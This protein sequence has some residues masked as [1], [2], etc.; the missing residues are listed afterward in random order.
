[1]QLRYLSSGLQCIYAKDNLLLKKVYELVYMSW[2]Q[3]QGP[4]LFKIQS[5]FLE[6]DHSIS[7]FHL[8]EHRGPGRKLIKT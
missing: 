5:R 7:I 3:H 8:G 2:Y 6:N 4:M 1:M